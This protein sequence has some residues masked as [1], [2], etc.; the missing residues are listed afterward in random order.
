MEQPELNHRKQRRGPEDGRRQSQKG[1]WI[2][3]PVLPEV[4]S[5]PAP[6]GFAESAR[7][8][9]DR[10]AMAK[11]RDYEFE[12]RKLIDWLQAPIME[13]KA[14]SDLIK[15]EADLTDAKRVQEQ[16]GFAR[17][18]KSIA[19]SAF[20]DLQYIED[21]EAREQALIDW[22]A[23]YAPLKNVAEYST[24]I[25]N[26]LNLVAQGIADIRTIKNLRSTAETRS[27]DALTADM[28]PEDRAK[29]ARVKA[30]LEAKPS[31][32]A[33]QYKIVEGPD[34]APQ[35]VAVNPRDVGAVALGTGEAAGAPFG[36]PIQPG[37]KSSMIGQSQKEKDEQEIQK[38][39]DEQRPKRLTSLRQAET[40]AD[41]MSDEIDSLITRVSA[42]TAGP[43][44]VVLEKFPG[45]SAKDFS[46]DL[47]SLK[48]NIG[49]QALQAMRE[50]SPTG[51]A[52]GQVSDFEN[53]NLQAVLG[54]L[55]IGSSPSKLIENLKKVRKSIGTS[56][57]T[58]KAA[59]GSEYGIEGTSD[60]AESL[61][62]MTDEQLR[63]RLQQ[64]RGQ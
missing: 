14:S 35:L 63:Q 40:L 54:S 28:S 3:M 15:A 51:G 19:D 61:S 62:S 60:P 11:Q 45:T 12:Q 37:A 46:N 27:F 9:M 31:G 44:G 43:G 36:T 56:I 6:S 38:K 55:D 34:G 1:G 39:R 58:S 7:S 41:R 47:N 48:A 32:A 20:D 17:K 57:A 8:L 24:E 21:P 50:A 49:F 22:S 10:A 16:I 5:T 33:I 26:K 64:L 30:G 18:Q 13:A 25:G 52:L 23:K 2:L 59:F 29:A 53:K 4:S 42:A